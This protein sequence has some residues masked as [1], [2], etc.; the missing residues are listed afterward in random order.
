MRCANAS[1]HVML[2]LKKVLE[3]YI[4]GG[5]YAFLYNEFYAFEFHEESDYNW[6]II[7]YVTTCW[8]T[9]I[10]FIDQAHIYTFT[11]E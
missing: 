8:W 1:R 11:H 10:L 2:S 4:V 6:P 7:S 5:M 3:C 9:T